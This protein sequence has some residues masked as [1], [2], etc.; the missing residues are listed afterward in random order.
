[1]NART[2]GW[3]GMAYVFVPD[4]GPPRRGRMQ[5]ARTKLTNAAQ[6]VFRG[7]VVGQEL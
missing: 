2:L 4:A 5:A 7:R 6:A 1:M 3:R